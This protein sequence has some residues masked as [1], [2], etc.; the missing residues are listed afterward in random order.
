MAEFADPASLLQL[1]SIARRD[2]RAHKSQPFPAVGDFAS[3]R[4]PNDPQ[5][6]PVFATFAPWFGQIRLDCGGWQGF[7]EQ[8]REGYWRGHLAPGY[9]LGM[10]GRTNAMSV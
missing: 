9:S 5:S 10:T 7:I 4:A 8:A 3:F 2:R 6:S 1:T